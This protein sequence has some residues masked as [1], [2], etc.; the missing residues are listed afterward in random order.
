MLEIIVGT[1]LFGLMTAT[2]ISTMMIDIDIWRT[3]RY[4]YAKHMTRTIQ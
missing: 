3:R 2:L 4:K 1:I